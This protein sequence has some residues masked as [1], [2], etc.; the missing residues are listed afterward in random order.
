MM[1]SRL[2]DCAI[3]HGVDAAVA[4]RAP[5][6]AARVSPVGL[7][8]HVSTAIRSRLSQGSW[9][10]QREEPQWLAP[11]YQWTL[12]LDALKSADRKSPGAGPHPR[13]SAW[14]R[15]YGQVIAG[16]TCARQVGTVQRWYDGAQRDSW[17]V[18]AVAFGV[19]SPSTVERPSARPRKTMTSTSG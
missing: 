3:S 17:E 6:I 14:E 16:D 19:D 15:T 12:D 11:A 2:R 18:R 5:V 4:A 10:C 9:L 8:A 13:S 1:P 7:A